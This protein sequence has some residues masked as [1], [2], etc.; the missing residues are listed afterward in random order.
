MFCNLSKDVDA[1]WFNN[2]LYSIN[3]YDKFY[4]LF[5]SFVDFKYINQFK[6]YGVQ[7]D[8]ETF[9]NNTINILLSVENF[10]YHTHYK[11][12]NKFGNFGNKYISIYL[13]N[14]FT[15]FHI[16]ENYIV[17]PIIYLQIDYYKKTFEK[18]YPSIKTNFSD[19][20]FCIQV[21][22]L[23][24]TNN[25]NKNIYDSINKLRS[26][27]YVD[28]IKNYKHLVGDKSC[29]HSDEL[30]NL[31]N[32]YKFIICF[33]NSHN[34]GYITEKVFNAFYSKS[35]PIYIGPDDTDKYLNKNSYLNLLNI[36]INYIN[37]LSQNES[38]YNKYLNN[39]KI[40]NFYNE[41]YLE[42]SKLFIENLIKNPP[43]YNKN[44]D[45]L[46]K[47]QYY[48][49]ELMDIKVISFSLWGNIKR[50][51]IGA[52]RNAELAK[53]LYPEFECWYYI[54]SSVPKEIIE[55]LQKFDN[56]KIIYKNNLD[57]DTC[58]PMCWRFEAISDSSVEM[59]VCRDA[60]SRLSKR[61]ELAVREW[62]D[63]DCYLH[64]IR[65]HKIYHNYKIFGG[66]FGI[67]K[68]P[69]MP[70]WKKE[71]N[72]YNQNRRSRM[73]DVGF[74]EMIIR[75]IS[76]DKVLAH[77]TSNTIFSNE[78]CKQFPTKYDSDYSFIGEYIDENE[79]PTLEHRLL[80]KNN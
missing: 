11:H 13:Y 59:M 78:I 67:K 30:L 36:D 22:F 16:S 20:K 56:V 12:F 25:Y 45:Y 27:G 5:L 58:K 29:Y 33:E 40:N 46:K 23:K 74:L 73:Y 21:S 75:D 49:E 2:K 48:I 7:D 10:N 47:S 41:D 32:N 70:D 55:E 18:I 61:E 37:K 28:D 68:Y 4:N 1:Y 63:S 52:I 43:S 9:D 53:I 24:Y 57:L 34:D 66:M 80:L 44:E 17:I 35:I 51:T 26:L 31:L 50:Y 60:D 3:N 39:K 79:N 62:L 54:H 65:D 6:I 19:K 38:E 64:I 14:H 77:S 71:I 69:N 8:N 72:N 42:K 15:N 76:K